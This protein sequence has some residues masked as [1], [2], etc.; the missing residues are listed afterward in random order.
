RAAGTPAAGIHH[1]R[2]P[3]ASAPTGMS[4]I[5]ARL[6]GT[7]G[8]SGRTRASGCIHGSRKRSPRAWG[9]RWPCVA[10]S[11]PTIAPMAPAPL[12]AVAGT[13]RFGARP[14]PR[15]G[16]E[17]P[18]GQIIEHRRRDHGASATS[19]W[20]PFVLLGALVLGVGLAAWR[21]IPAGV[22]HDDG[23]YM[24]VGRALA[25]GHGFTYQGVVG[26]P[27]A[28]KFPP[29]YPLFL[30]GLWTLFGEIGPVTLAATL[31]NLGFLA[32]AAVFLA[33]SFHV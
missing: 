18:G 31:A 17:P 11:R 7:D 22:W 28:V 12:V 30:A 27:P 29:V 13:R 10:G 19:G 2:R 14:R 32:A 33:R 25:E 6:V 24:L 3:A 5:T 20:M 15:P 9:V 8:S 16:S 23:V 4:A 1:A 21:P 26:A